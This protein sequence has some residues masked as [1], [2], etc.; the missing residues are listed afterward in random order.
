MTAKKRTNDIAKSS[1]TPPTLDFTIHDVASTRT[2]MQRAWLIV[3]NAVLALCLVVLLGAVGLSLMAR[4]NGAP[5]SVAG[6]RP[7]I[8]ATASMEPA[9]AVDGLVVSS[10]AGFATVAVGDVVAFRADGLNGQTALHRV[11]A[12]S[13]EGDSAKLIVKGDN[14]AHPD[15]APVTKDNYVGRVVFH[16]NATATFF[17]TLRR[18]NGVFFAIIL[19]LIILTLLYFASRWIVSGARGWRGKGLAICF[20]VTLA[21]GSLL[22]SFTLSTM[23]QINATNAGLAKI[24]Q[25]FATSGT[26]RKW[27]VAGSEVL[28]S[29]EIPKIGVL[30]P[31]IP[32]VS[33][34]S[35]NVS[36]TH[37]SGAGLNQPGND[38]LAGH[39]LY[40]QR[41]PFG[42][43][44][45]HIDKLVVGDTI[46]I[47]DATRHR[48][49]YRV[50]GYK[51]VAPSDTSVL[52]QPNDGKK[53][54]TL[55]S[56]SYDLLNRYIVTA[57][58]E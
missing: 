34:S 32:Y 27:S 39:R 40:G 33:A 22:V 8:I 37:F 11:I 57:V 1:R 36:I 58:A 24:S 29:V 16:T 20:I 18:P 46:Y 31:I 54:L 6:F 19:P 52:S 44:F 49:A 56:C 9:F 51:T 2:P 4:H 53:H 43:F 26:D 38:V 21:A 7:Y 23:K 5:A 48:Q 15:G 10:D 41:S 30:Y 3:S 25:D 13:G 50:T 28:G 45:T 55:I 12:K 35:L 14:N 47:T 17:V 42:L